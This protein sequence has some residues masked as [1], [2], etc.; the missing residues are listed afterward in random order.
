MSEKWKIDL[1]SDLPVPKTKA[2]SLQA[3][4]IPQSPL[5]KFPLHRENDVKTAQCQL[6]RTLEIE[7][8]SNPEVCKFFVKDKIVNI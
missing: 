1:Y 4:L 5:T 2:N 3:S 7:S 6:H 8:Y